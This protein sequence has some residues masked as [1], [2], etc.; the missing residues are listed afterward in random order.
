MYSS[1]PS[2][3][4]DNIVLEY[5]MELTTLIIRS[6]SIVILLRMYNNY[7]TYQMKIKCYY[8]VI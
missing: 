5:A 6:T 3:T 2:Y 8:L 1:H 4:V 7:E